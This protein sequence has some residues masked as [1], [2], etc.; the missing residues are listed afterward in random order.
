LRLLRLLGLIEMVL[1]APVIP[2]GG[3]EL[4]RADNGSF[5]SRNFK[6]AFQ[7]HLPTAIPCAFCEAISSQSMIKL[8]F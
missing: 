1:A 6:P 4:Y 2:Y 7:I 3:N 8:G 5:K